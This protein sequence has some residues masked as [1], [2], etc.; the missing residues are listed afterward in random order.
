MRQVLAHELT[1]GLLLIAVGWSLPAAAQGFPR[2]AVRDGHFV[3]AEGGRA[4]AP[5]GVNYFRTG[6]ADGGKVVHAT[7]CP[8]FYDRTFIEKMM[9]DLQAWGFNTVRTFQV[10]YVGPSGILTS[11]QA[12]EISPA[13]LANV[14]H[15]LQQARQH[16]V[17]VI[18]SWDIW[19]PTSEWWASQPLP[20][21]AKYDLHPAWD[22]AAGMNNF[23]FGRDSVRTRVNG[24]LELIRAIG[25]VD[26]DLLRVV[27]AWE[28]ENEVVFG[29]DRVPFSKRG[30]TFH[31]GGKDYD[32]ASDEQTQAL[33]D[34]IIVQWANVGAG[35]IHAA[36]PQVLVSASV[37]TFAAAGRG[38]PGTLSRDKTGDNRIPA[39]PLAL[40]RS[41]LDYLD[42][43]SYAWR[44]ETESVASYLDKNLA[45]EEWPVLSAQ[46][47]RAGKP[48]LV[49]ESGVFA[50]YL[51]KPPG[52][53]IDHALGVACLREHLQGLKAHGL[54]GLLYWPYGS[55]DSTPNDE[56]PALVCCPQYVEVLQ[57]TWG[58]GQERAK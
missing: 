30:G 34:E 25:K 33:M 40:L 19:L 31:F 3:E 44:S 12:R 15:F 23:R 49:G 9:A 54:A 14:I 47:K 56:T 2:I 52:W 5:V 58:R 16:G 45:S 24:I 51:R 6:K 22:E 39:R 42:I 43:H 37:F 18:F 29:A 7:F 50:N 11:P 32:L 1:V 35:A 26:P 4:F 8:G 20:D 57:E 46:A 36:D 38:R 17:H 10:Y 55:P 21:E 28:L 27:M 53:G 41:G 13:Y 48:V